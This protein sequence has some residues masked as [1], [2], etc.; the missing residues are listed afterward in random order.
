MIRA[1]LP[2]TVGF[3][4]AFTASGAVAPPP[5]LSL[6]VQAHTIASTGFIFSEKVNF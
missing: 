2:V 5:P 6:P 1:A 3:A 4:A